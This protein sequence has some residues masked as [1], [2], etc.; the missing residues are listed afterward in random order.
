MIQTWPLCRPL[1]I[2]NH[3]PQPKLRM[4]TLAPKPSICV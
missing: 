2:F 1:E 4:L 3:E